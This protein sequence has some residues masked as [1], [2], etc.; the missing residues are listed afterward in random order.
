VTLAEAGL[1]AATLVLRLT[2]AAIFVAQ[3]WR[4]LI[5]PPDAPHG[6]NGLTAMIRSRGM[7]APER[8]ARAVALTELA[9]GCLLAVG[10][11]TRV[12]AIPLAGILVVAITG[13]KI[14]QGFLAGWDWPLACLAIVVS[15]FLLG[16]G[17]L[18]LDAVLGIP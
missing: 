17:R 13:F 12:V 8:L 10:L 1:V 11:L 4:K 5:D 9:G 16:G 18:S 2:A 3:G 15:L 7:P 6:L 14:R